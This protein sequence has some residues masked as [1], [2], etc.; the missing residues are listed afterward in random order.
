MENNNSN[1][2]KIRAKR[3]KIKDI[4]MMMIKM[5][6]NTN[7]MNINNVNMMKNNNLII[8]NN[9]M[10]NNQNNNIMNKHNNWSNLNNIN[11]YYKKIQMR[12]QGNLKLEIFKFKINLKRIIKKI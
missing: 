2:K 4:N 11:K 1:Y 5:G 8:N 3:L 12:M 7:K 6:N 10:N 9:M